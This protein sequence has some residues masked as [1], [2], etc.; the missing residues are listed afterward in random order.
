MYQQLTLPLELPKNWR[1]NEFLT[2]VSN[3]EAL[4]WI[5]RWPDFPLLQVVIHGEIGCGKSH[6]GE[7]LARQN[8]GTY[9]GKIHAFQSPDHLFVGEPP[10]LIID[11]Y[12]LM[13]REDWLFHVYNMAT[14]TRTPVIYFGKMAPAQYSFSL[15]DLESR[16]R[17]LHAIEILTPD[18]GFFKK[19]LQ[20]RLNILGL[21][22]SDEISEYVFRRLERSY[23]ALHGFVDRVDAL[24]LQ[25]QRS[26]S[27]PFIR[28]ILGEEVPSL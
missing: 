1:L 13:G 6:L 7:S 19:L 5:H 24:S 28:E 16:M 21:M 17:S 9:V 22:C 10:L 12:D 15:P 11:D 20:H 3:E 26:L 2:G 18:E 14:E 8:Q 25:Q 23:A 4:A 27:L